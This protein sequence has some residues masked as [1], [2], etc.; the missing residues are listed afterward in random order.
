MTDAIRIL[1]LEVQTRVGVSDEERARAQ[2]VV[3]DVNIGVDL[4]RAG[5]S[6]ALDDTLDYSAA[7]TLVADTIA[8]S[9]A[10]LLEHL[11]TRVISVVSR[12]D[13]V[14]DVT[15]QI[16]KRPPPVAEK[17]DSVA[18]RMVGPGT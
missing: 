8:A 4:T 10:R 16:A 3:V 13:G 17:V 11:A 5:A 2:T 12:M 6:D 15:V 1:G 18:I 9:E 7:V 14:E